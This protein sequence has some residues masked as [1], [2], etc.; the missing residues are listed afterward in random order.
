MVWSCKQNASG[1]ASQTS[2]TCEGKRPVGRP[3]TRWA[4]YIENLGWNRFGLQPSEML[5]VVVDRD[6][7]RLNFK[8]LPP[9]T[10]TDMSGL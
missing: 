1:K 7:W 2:F 5:E 6:V 9:E 3:R 4:D 8:L 10:L